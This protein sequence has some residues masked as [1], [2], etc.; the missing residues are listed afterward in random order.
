MTHRDH[1][2]M[3]DGRVEQSLVRVDAELLGFKDETLAA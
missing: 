2:S 3:V 1:S